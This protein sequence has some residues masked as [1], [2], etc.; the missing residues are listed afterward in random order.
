MTSEEKEYYDNL[1]NDKSIN[2]YVFDRLFENRDGNMIP[3]KD[4]HF[5]LMGGI[6]FVSNAVENQLISG[7]QLQKPE[8][9]NVLSGNNPIEVPESLFN[10]KIIILSLD[11]NKKGTFSDSFYIQ[12][13]LLKLGFGSKGLAALDPEDLDKIGNG[14]ASDSILT[15][16]KKT[17]AWKCGSIMKKDGSPKRFII[18]KTR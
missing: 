16:S 11:L 5:Q 13:D 9:K 12:R 2:E 6:P 8:F 15:A 14:A 1:K 10:K 4:K 18:L 7:M 3:I 17:K